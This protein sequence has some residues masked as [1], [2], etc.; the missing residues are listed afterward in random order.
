MLV[1]TH[2]IQEISF[3]FQSSQGSYPCV[4]TFLICP[5][6]SSLKQ[7]RRILEHIT[8]KFGKMTPYCRVMATK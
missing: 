6:D 4:L 7:T 8:K 2:S 1:K 3:L 5:L